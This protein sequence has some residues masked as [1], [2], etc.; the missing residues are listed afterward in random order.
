MKSKSQPEKDKVHLLPPDPH[1]VEPGSEP[2]ENDQWEAFCQHYLIRPC[3]SDAAIKAGY[4]EKE[5]SSKGCQL[6]GIVRVYDRIR[7]LQKKQAEALEIEGNRIVRELTVIALSNI[8]DFIEI[9]KEKRKVPVKG[10]QTKYSYEIVE[11]LCLKDGIPEHL[12]SAISSIHQTKDGI[13]I[14]LHPKIPALDKLGVHL[15]LWDSRGRKEDE[16][17][18]PTVEEI[19]RE[20]FGD[21][22]QLPDGFEDNLYQAF[23][24]QCRKASNKLSEPGD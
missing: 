22:F 18:I 14:T 17:K 11:R 24:N 23:V 2:L 21:D 1:Y 7:F 20:I 15:G 4:S 6:Y 10:N 9:K 5:A 19:E 13:R 8:M 12:S 3:F 16:E